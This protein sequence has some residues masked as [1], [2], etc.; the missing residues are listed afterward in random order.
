MDSKKLRKRSLTEISEW[1]PEGDMASF[2]GNSCSQSDARRT[3]QL[4]SG[5]HQ[6]GGEGRGGPVAWAT[7]NLLTTAQALR[8]G[9]PSL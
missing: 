1:R 4:S 3:V 7:Q 5:S 6:C 8:Y 9:T 2:T